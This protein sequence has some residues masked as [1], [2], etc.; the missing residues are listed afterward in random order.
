MPNYHPCRLF[1]SYDDNK[2]N[3]LDNTPVS[4]IVMMA[5]TP[6]FIAVRLAFLLIS[7]LLHIVSSVDATVVELISSLSL[8]TLYDIYEKC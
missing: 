4:Q 6:T 1:S 7:H 3:Q 5:I 8:A 2:N